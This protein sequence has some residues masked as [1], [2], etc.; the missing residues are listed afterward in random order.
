MHISVSDSGK[1]LTEE[2]LQRVFDRFYREDK[3]RRRVTGGSGLGLAIV[4]ALVELHEG[5]ISVKNH[6][7]AGAVFIV[8]LLRASSG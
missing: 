1:G 7:S 2:G 5:T 8:Q 3:S 4:K 6:P